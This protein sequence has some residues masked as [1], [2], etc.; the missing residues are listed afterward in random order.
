MNKFKIEVRCESCKTSYINTYLDKPIVGCLT[1]CTSPTCCRLR[2]LTTEDLQEYTP[3]S[4]ITQL[5]ASVPE[6]AT[7]DEW[8][9]LNLAP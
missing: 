3:A 8:R 1:V 7:Y 9:E 5:P 2:L 6:D 4:T